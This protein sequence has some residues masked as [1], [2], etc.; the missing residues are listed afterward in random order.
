MIP[1]LAGL[2]QKRKFFC[3]KHHTSMSQGVC[4]SQCMKTCARS[5]I[6]KCIRNRLSEP[7]GSTPRSPYSL[8]DLSEGT[9]RD[10]EVT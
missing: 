10:R 2:I 1:A 6:F 5:V 3:E 9:F 7:L 8:A 4:G